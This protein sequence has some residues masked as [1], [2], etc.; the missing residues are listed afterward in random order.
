M[1][2]GAAIASLEFKSS[3][4]GLAA[5]RDRLAAILKRHVH[6][7][8]L[9]QKSG[10]TIVSE[11]SYETVENPLGLG[12]M[13][14]AAGSTLLCFPGRREGY[15][16]IVKLP[17]LGDASQSRLS[18]G[19]AYPSTSIV[20]AHETALAALTITPDGRWLA[21]AS[22]KGTLVRVFDARTAKLSKE[23]RRGADPAR[24]FSLA[25]RPDGGGVA[26]AS[27]KGTVHIF[28]FDAPS[29]RSPTPESGSS[30]RR[31]SAERQRTDSS[32]A[33]DIKPYLPKYFQSTW[34]DAQFRLP[35]PEPV[36]ARKVSSYLGDLIAEEKPERP[37]TVEDD[38]VLCCWTFD[39]KTHEWMLCAITQSGGWFKLAMLT[40]DDYQEVK[41]EKARIAAAKAKGKGRQRRDSEEVEKR[42]DEASLGAHGRCRLVQYSRFEERDG[43]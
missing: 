14:S 38:H 11:G 19:T 13:A 42:P 18:R 4:L 15:V 29:A 17:P 23:L 7:F 2:K 40:E 5:R 12:C 16:S 32:L 36:T 1:L 8:A 6:L 34:S 35:P 28:N 22:T 24:I 3:V 30:P 20:V 43:W 21:T 26:C 9:P 37:F 41:R 10:Q 27:D 33:G 31:A 39:D 25:L